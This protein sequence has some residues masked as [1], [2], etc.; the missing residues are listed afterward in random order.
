VYFSVLRAMRAAERE[1]CEGIRAVV[2]EGRRVVRDVPGS[3]HD[4]IRGKS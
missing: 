2:H 4:K 3:K 1:R